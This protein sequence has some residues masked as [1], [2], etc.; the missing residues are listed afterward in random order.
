MGDVEQ[1]RFAQLLKRVFGTRAVNPGRI[2]TPA[3]SPTAD[4]Q[5][6]YQPENRNNRGE[7]L[8]G[9]GLT[10]MNVG[11]ANM[12]LFTIS[13]P[14][15]SNRITVIKKVTVSLLVPPSTAQA[16]GT[17]GF[18]IGNPSVGSAGGISVNSRD[19][20]RSNFNAPLSTIYTTQT[21]GTINLQTQA[22]LSIWGFELDPTTVTTNSLYV[23]RD[24]LD[25]VLFANVRCELGFR[26]QVL[27][28]TA[29]NYT[30]FVEGYE[31][32]IDPNELTAVA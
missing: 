4:V 21:V 20:R 24:E 6:V 14:A 12:G 27:P 9:A 25:I 8:W 16:L 2:L 17:A 28:S 18:F 30:I 19:S 32:T 31:R 23:H 13:N 11:L 26:T 5:D 29:W 3:V 7:A 15:N 22:T 1:L 10:P